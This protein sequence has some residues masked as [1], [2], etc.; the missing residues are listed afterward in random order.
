MLLIAGILPNPD[1]PLIHGKVVQKKS[2]LLVGEYS[3][4][5]S[6]GTAAMVSAALAVTDLLGVQ[7]PEVILAGDIGTGEG[8]RQVYNYIIENY[9]SLY[10]SVLSLHY[11]MPD[12]QLTRNLVTA[13]KNRAVKPILIADAASMY[14]AKAAGLAGHFDVFTPD[15]SELAFLADSEA[16][17]PAYIDKHLFASDHSRIPELINIAYENKNASRLMVVKG[18]TDYIV[19]EGTILYTIKEPDVPELECIGGTGDTITG[20]LSALIYAGYEPGQAALISTTVN[21]RAGQVGKLCPASSVNELINS[22]SSILTGNL[23]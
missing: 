8:S 21:R 17:H 20:M 6:Q 5:C 9:D 23:G 13:V 16:I 1:L 22:L 2:N 10:P 12:L 18:K 3:I 14:S 11:W 15:L 19:K 4:P 7:P